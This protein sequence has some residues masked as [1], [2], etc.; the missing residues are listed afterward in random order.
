VYELVPIL[1]IIGLGA[2]TLGSIVGVGG[3]VI[4]V[5]ALT[6]LG[7]QPT[8]ISSTS[9]VAVSATSVSSTVE[10]SRQRRLD[11]KLSLAMAAAAVPGAL[12]G[13]FLSKYFTPESFRLDFA[14]VL[15]LAG[16]YILY[17]KSVLREK[18]EK[19]TSAVKYV[20]VGVSC[21]GAGII[22]SLFGVGGGIIFVP[23]MLLLLGIRM[24]RAA[25]NSQLILM[26][27]SIAGV[28]AHAYLGHPD[29][30]AAAALSVGAFAGGQ[31]G[32]R[33]SRKAQDSFLQNLLGIFLLAVA[34]K[35]IYDW[36]SG[37]R[38]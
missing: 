20:V 13:A 32:A 11:Y 3:G 19:K 38:I 8:Q 25:P 37:T 28:A 9:L 31:V 18:E 29:Y 6:L 27:T 14:I 1:I 33:L 21:F 24:H 36:F 17:K 23:V 16:L 4:M 34:G 7:L 26:I 2:G 5:P 10:Y 22:S 12:V 35:F 15:A 30:L